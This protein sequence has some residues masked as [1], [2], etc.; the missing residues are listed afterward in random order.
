[1]NKTISSRLAR[2][3]SVTALAIFCVNGNILASGEAQSPASKPVPPPVRKPSRLSSPYQPSRFPKRAG[4][5]YGEVWGIDSLTVKTTESGEL[6]RFSY[7]V[8]NADKAG[9]LNDKKSQPKLVD[10]RAG[11]E[12]VIP[13][14]EKVGQLRQSSTP[15]DGKIYWMAF[16][17]AGRRVKKGDQVEV[18]IGP[19]RAQGLVVD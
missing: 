13:S 14:L 11:V 12:L 2:L 3:A 18:H 17:N 1:M 10:P 15:V 6:I 19:F 7:R 8:L 9:P 5:Y 16:S 4:M